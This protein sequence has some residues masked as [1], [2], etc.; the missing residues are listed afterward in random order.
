MDY[1]LILTM[2]LIGHFL[3]D[4]YFQFPIIADEK[5]EKHKLM[6]GHG[7]IY[8][9]MV[10][11]LVVPFVSI[12]WTD[13]L[14][15]LIVVPV[16][17]IVFDIIK[18]RWI[19]NRKFFKER[20]AN[21]FILDQMVHIAAIFTVACFC[22]TRVE[23]AY[24]WFGGYVANIYNGL[25]LGIPISRLIRLVCLLLFLGKPVN[26]LL[27]KIF[28]DKVYEKQVE[29]KQEQ[30][31]EREEEQEKEE[32]GQEKEGQEKEEEGQE[33]EEE[34]QEKEKE[35]QEKEKEG[36]EQEE[37]GQEKEEEGQEQEEE[38]QEKE[39]EQAKKREQQ[40]GRIIGVL[41]RYLIVILVITQEYGAIGFVVTAKSLTRFKKISDDSTFAEKYLIGT[42]GSMLL[43]IVGAVL[44]TYI[45]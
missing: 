34:G 10:G 35:G 29:S 5:D 24:S 20:K 42:M 14:W 18:G 11:G 23:V 21:L 17:H 6:I 40:A 1:K 44:Y 43:A 39:E 38:G 31:T 26:I 15:P 19:K 45:P 27:Q 41:E 22:A 28:E 2:L 25:D 9:F 7:V 3:G 8:L 30:E 4:F 13:W 12:H 32:E 16:S 37:E 33:K 36:Q